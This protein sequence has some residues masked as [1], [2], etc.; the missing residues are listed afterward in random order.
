MES[1]YIDRKNTALSIGQ[2]RIL[3]K[4]PNQPNQSLPLH[5]IKRIVLATNVSFQSSF[6]NQLAKHNIDFLVINKKDYQNSC[7]L[8]NPFRHNPI[9][10]IKQY[11]LVT[12]YKQTTNLANYIVIKKLIKQAKLIHHYQY[13][14]TINRRTFLKALK[15]LYSMIK[16]L[17][18]AQLSTNADT[19][20]GIEGACAKSYF[21]CY[22]QL[23]PN[24]L[25]FN[26]RNKRPPKDPINSLL[27]L[28]YTIIHHDAC[29]A[30]LAKG[31]DPMLGC[32]HKLSYSRQSLACDLV[33]LL[34]TDIDLWVLKLIHQKKF[35]E[36]D[37]YYQQQACLLSKQG[38]EKYFPL[39]EAQAKKW[40]KKLNLYSNYFDKWL[41]NNA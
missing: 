38:R 31:F 5:M 28:T 15:Q 6:L 34:R 1:V 29:R 23:I 10:R 40:R 9:K 37:F 7:L 41:N 12:D 21:T 24:K 14:K 4:I 19:L 17:K 2:G 26:G 32:L 35:I 36:S 3:I 39:L 22:A 27:S 13:H 30:L 8:I 16:L 33:E 20:L 25:S 11:Q 18:S